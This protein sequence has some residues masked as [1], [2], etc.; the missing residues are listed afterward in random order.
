MNSKEQ[1]CDVLNDLIE[2]VIDSVDGY[3]KAADVAKDSGLQSAFRESATRRQGVIQS[4]RACVAKLG[5]EAEDDG[6]IL[7]AAHRTLMGLASMVES[8]NEAAAEAVETGEK[9]IN[10]KFKDALEDEDLGTE[11]RSVIHP[12]YAEIQTDARIAELVAKIHD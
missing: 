5:G 1:D 3:N 4:L 7:A 9:H 11:A 12:A 2:T 10:D 6:T 8:N